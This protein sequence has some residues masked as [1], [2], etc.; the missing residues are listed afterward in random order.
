M[1][2]CRFPLVEDSIQQ[3]SSINR[4]HTHSSICPSSASTNSLIEAY[5]RNS[6]RLDCHYLFVP[7]N[8]D[9]NF[10]LLFR[11]TVDSESVP[12]EASTSCLGPVCRVAEC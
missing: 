7:L 3:S 10:I 9:N 2:P 5:D 4:D 6:S 12:C 1:K 8:F 11:D